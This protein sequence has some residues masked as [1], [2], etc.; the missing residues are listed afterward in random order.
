MSQPCLLQKNNLDCD[1]FLYWGGEGKVRIFPVF[2]P[3]THCESDG[4][5]KN[6]KLCA[7]LE[8]VTTFSAEGHLI[9]TLQNNTLAAHSAALFSQTL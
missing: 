9:F 6:F 7:K 8:K 4:D 1:L 2:F 3:Q 5:R